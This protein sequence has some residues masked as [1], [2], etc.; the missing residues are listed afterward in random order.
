M[1]TRLKILILIKKNTRK[2]INL[3]YILNKTLFKNKYIKINIKNFIPKSETLIF[4]KINKKIYNYK[5][6][7][8]LCSGTGII[9]KENKKVDNVDINLTSIYKIKNKSIHINT[10][11]ILPNKKIYNIISNNP[12]Y[13]C[14][15]D[16]IFYYNFK[17]IKQSLYINLKGLNNL[18]ISI[19]KIINTISKNCCI[20]NEHGYNQSKFLRKIIKYNG[21]INTF[22]IKDY[23]NLERITY[24]EF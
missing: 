13:L 4:L 15:K 1:I 7:I 11:Y 18:L 23:S 24:S 19:K 8:E 5:K 17:E 14:F 12:P 9:N 22:T 21:L 20:I 16:F 10:K 2:E 3:N 6:C